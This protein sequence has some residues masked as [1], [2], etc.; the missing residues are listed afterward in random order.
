[1]T[2]ILT[3]DPLTPDASLIDL[4]VKILRDGGVIAY[5]TETLYGLAADAGNDRAI[6][7]I[8]AIKGR[9][10]DKPIPLIIGNEEALDPLVSEIPERAL[11]LMKTFWPGPL[12]LIFNASDR[13]STRLTAGTGKIGIRLSSNKIAR[14]LAAHL[15]GAIT[16]TSANISGEGGISSPK[17]VINILENRIDALID[18]GDTPGGPG[19]TVVDV[20]TDPP[21]VLREGII[22][23]STVF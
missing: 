20:T 9:N 21:I 18:G 7:R 3:I 10:F 22:R 1:M 6:E 12:T 8:F 17:E 11:P 16:A 5:P 4:G 13:V 14:H 2:E 15:N 19:S 23:S